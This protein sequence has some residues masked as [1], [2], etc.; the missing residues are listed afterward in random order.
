LACIQIFLGAAPYPVLLLCGALFFGFLSIVVPGVTTAL[1]ILNL[2]FTVRILLGAFLAKNLLMQ[3]AVTARLPA[4][5]TTAE[6]M[7][8]G[9]LAVFLA[10]FLACRY[11]K[12]FAIF[13]RSTTPSQLL[14]LFYVLLI[15]GVVSSIA[16]RAV[17]GDGA[18][19]TGGAW[20]LIKS[21]TT[22]RNL[23]LPIL[24]L[25]LWRTNSRR[26]LTHPGVLLLM[27]VL[28]VLGLLSFSKQQVV[29]PLIFPAALA[30]ARYGWRHPMVWIFV[31]F[32]LLVFEF[33]IY[34]VVQYSKGNV[35]NY[36]DAQQAAAASLGVVR[37]YI[38][39]P[40]FRQY[41]RE[42]SK[43]EGTEIEGSD[44]LSRDYGS[45]ERIALLGEASRLIAAS[46]RFQTTGWET[47]ENSVLLAVPH[48]LYP[49]K[50]QTGSGNFLAR[51]AGDL[52]PSD[53]STQVSYGFIANSYNAFGLTW[54]FPLC[55]ITALVVLV[56][57]TMITSGPIY[58]NPWSMYAVA[59]LH[60]VY[61]ESSFSGQFNA[62]FLPFLAICLL[63][64]SRA[65]DWLMQQAGIFPQALLSTERRFP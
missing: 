3:E 49:N 36:K 57:V 31:P 21:F 4:A 55:F 29:E 34:P 13:Q 11:I 53:V 51:Y 65:C 24:M 41:L 40:S 64:L 38:S 45:L 5:E 15:G 12:P 59:G 20:G 63:L 18:V 43:S 42:G 39:D 1:G 47:I 56:P 8:L 61:V 25:Y 14:P 58:L 28:V 30:I 50:P 60:Q 26:W 44:Y 9:F 23:S 54:V 37:D 27:V 32:F 48:F 35:A 6:A 17:S 62:L 52:P 22:V 19:A 10:T 33:F 46:D 16:L 7:F 2:A